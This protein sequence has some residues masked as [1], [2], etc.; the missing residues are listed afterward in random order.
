MGQLISISISAAK[1]RENAAR[2]STDKNGNQ[3]VQL[4]VSVNDN[5]DQ[6]GKDVQVWMEQSKEE[7][8]AKTDRIFCGG[9]KVVYGK[10]A[11]ATGVPAMPPTPAAAAI[12]SDTLPF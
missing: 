10:V 7:R 1:L 4:T 2:F 3:W 6:Y 5:P 9:G 11:P 8:D 12:E